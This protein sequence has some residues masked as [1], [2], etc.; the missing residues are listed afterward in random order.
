MG[1]VWNSG[2]SQA[3]TRECENFG[4][5]ADERMKRL[6]VRNTTA[7]TSS[8][9]ARLGNHFDLSFLVFSTSALGEASDAGAK[10]VTARE[11]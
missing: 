7:C 3:D 5:S 10:P 8:G 1:H 6:G 4:C 11:A 2:R 9:L